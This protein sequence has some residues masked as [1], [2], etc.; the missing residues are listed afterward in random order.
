MINAKHIRTTRPSPSLDFKNRGP[1]RIIRAIDNMAYEVE[2]PP[3]LGRLHNVF[4]PWLLH[5]YEGQPLPQQTRDDS[6]DAQLADPDIDDDNEYYVEEVLKSRIDRHEPDPGNR[7]RKGLLQYYVKWSN[8]PVGPDNPSWE[9][10]M[11]LVGSADLVATFHRLH[12]KSP[13]PHKNFATLT[14]KQN[15]VMM[16]LAQLSQ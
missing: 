10:Y 11:N 3:G 5:L 6:D 8:Y 16:T 9:P 13:G 4:H 15:L 14:E 1:F 7:D 12:P 2:L